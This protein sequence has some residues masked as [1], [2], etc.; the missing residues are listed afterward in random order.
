MND[1]N[2]EHVN[3]N[4]KARQDVSLTAEEIAG[5]GL[6]SSSFYDPNDEVNIP[7]NWA[8]EYNS[9]GSKIKISKA[10]RLKLTASTKIR[11][12]SNETKLSNLAVKLSTSYIF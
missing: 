1:T 10:F 8:H 4:G 12:T 11:S 7:D 2:D 5:S 6:G 3:F 9:L